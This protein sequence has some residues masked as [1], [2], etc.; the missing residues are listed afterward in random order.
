[1]ATINH[2]IYIPLEARN[3]RGRHR[4]L[5]VSSGCSLSRYLKDCDG[6]DSEF[7]FI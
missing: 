7:V 1:M 2:C 4:D 3:L 5:Y 6:V